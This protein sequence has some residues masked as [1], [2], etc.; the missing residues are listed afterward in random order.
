MEAPVW[1]SD[2]NLHNPFALERNER[3]ICWGKRDSHPKEIWFQTALD[4][5]TELDHSSLYFSCMANCRGGS[6][7]LHAKENRKTTNHDK[8]D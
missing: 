8:E 2:I 7:D 4:A 1:A 5:G 6:S 3:D